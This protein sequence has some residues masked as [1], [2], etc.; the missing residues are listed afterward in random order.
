MEARDADVEFELLPRT[1][2]QPDT[3]HRFVLTNDRPATAVRLN[4]FPDGG[5]ARLRLHG[6]LTEEALAEMRERFETL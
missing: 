4:I 1:R 5:M 6:R 3:P 2:L